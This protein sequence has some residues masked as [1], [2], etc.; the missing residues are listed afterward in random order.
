M[1]VQVPRRSTAAIAAQLLRFSIPLILSAILQQLYSWADAFIVGNV[2]GDIA[3]AAVGA[4][5][6][7]TWFFTGALTSFTAGLTILFA[8]SWG[9][10]ERKFMTATLS[11]FSLFWG[12]VS[13][14]MSVLGYCFTGPLLRLLDTTADTLAL[15][16]QYLK[17]CFVGIPFLAQYN[18]FSAALRGLGDSKVS[19]YAVAVSSVTNIVLDLWFVAGLGWSVAGA[20]WATVLSQIGM[21]VFVVI[22]ALRKEPGLRFRPGRAAFDGEAFRQGWKFG[23]PPMIQT[24]VTS[25]GNM[26]LQQFMNG[27]GTQTV[28]AITTAYRIDSIVLAPMFSL[29]TGISTLCAQSFGAGEGKQTRRIFWA[30]TGVMAVISLILTAAV[31]PVGGSLTALFGASPEAVAIGREFFRCIAVFYIVLGLSSAVRSY[32]EAIGDL[33]FSSIC[34]IVALVARILASY[35]M[36]PFFGNMTVAYAEAL[37]WALQLVIYALRFVWREGRQKS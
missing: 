12:A 20:A 23:L 1:A 28:T 25:G 4:T 36:A 34:G 10:G 35:A 15:A 24:G 18:V 19:F 8:Q 31:I 33:K 2:E 6:S 32:L 16:E 7:V 11:T 5:G 21:T 37:S 26:I 22:Y 9:R 14:G 30:G 17:I 27:F 29:G 13:L 3:L